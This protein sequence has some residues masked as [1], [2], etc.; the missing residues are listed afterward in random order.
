MGR[1]RLAGAAILTVVVTLAAAYLLL[2]VI[3][4]TF[5]RALMLT[6]NGCVW[7]A[8]SLSSGTDGWTIVTTVGR[9]A[10][11]AIVTPQASGLIAALAVVGA[12]AL[13]G[14]QRLFESE[15]E[16]SK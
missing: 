16:S 1:A 8:A 13:Y 14:L 12:L 3:V 6:V 2:P 15:Q 10:A 5:V 9:A 11:H 4:V 7:L